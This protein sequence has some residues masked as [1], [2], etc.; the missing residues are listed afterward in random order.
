MYDNESA[1]CSEWRHLRIT[2]LDSAATAK[3]WD[4]L[5]CSFEAGK[6]RIRIMLPNVLAEEL[7]AV[8]SNSALTS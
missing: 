5:T 2:P 8:N 3:R 1:E 6:R 4:K 7:P